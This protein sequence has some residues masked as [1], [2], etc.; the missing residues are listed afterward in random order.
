MIPTAIIRP[1]LLIITAA[2]VGVTG[3]LAGAVA[4]SQFEMSLNSSTSVVTVG[5]PFTVSVDVLADEPTNVFSGTVQFDPTYFSVASI[6]YNTSLANIWAVEPW[7][8]D[9]DGTVT[10]A[11]GTTK[12]EGYI[13]SETLLTIT[14]NPLQTGVSE[15]GIEDVMIL[16]H[17]GLGSKVE[18]NTPL[19]VV[20]TIEPATLAE[21]TVF[22]K[23]VTGPS[24]TIL[25]ERPNVD[26]NNDGKQSTADF[27]IFMLHLASQNLRS[28]FD[29][30]GYVS[31]ADLRILTR[32]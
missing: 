32:Y 28:D 13:G 30:D 14:F 5:E 15:L 17:D 27:S 6:D 9:G 25:K 19:D 8:S 24:M 16:R 10:F 11:G 23:S 4:L 21:E 12:R 29:K 26:L 18:A 2:A 20:F 3:W 1:A 22:R 7:F 31:L